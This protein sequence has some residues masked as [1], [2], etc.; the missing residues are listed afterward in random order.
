MGVDS[1]MSCHR[2]DGFWSCKRKS[3]SFLQKSFLCFFHFLVSWLKRQV[4]YTL[5][6][7]TNCL[8]TVIVNNKIF[9]VENLS[10]RFVR[11]AVFDTI[12]FYLHEGTRV[13]SILLQGLYWSAEMQVLLVYNRS[14]LKMYLIRVIFH[15]LGC[16]LI[17]HNSTAKGLKSVNCVQL[18]T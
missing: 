11:S 2:G 16:H 15:Q 5:S 10:K 8:R 12:L 4:S 1:V 9:H 13:E 17:L 18:A 7:S 3:F 6:F 14:C